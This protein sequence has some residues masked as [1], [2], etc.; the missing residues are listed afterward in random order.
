[1]KNLSM[2]LEQWVPVDGAS[3]IDV[4]D[5]ESLNTDEIEDTGNSGESIIPIIN[6]ND[7]KRVGDLILNSENQSINSAKEESKKDADD[8]TKDHISIE[9]ANTSPTNKDR[10][11]LVGKTLD[12]QDHFFP[13]EKNSSGKYGWI[14]N[15]P[16]SGDN[17]WK[18]FTEY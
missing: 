1:M 8:Y 4:L 10:V 18:D 11:V 14:N 12:G 15:D 7:R 3:P 2:L 17:K 16:T 5:D 9:S 6:T 13:V